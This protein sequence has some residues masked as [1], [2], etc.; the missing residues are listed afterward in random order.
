MFNRF[1]NAFRLT[2]GKLYMICNMVKRK[3]MIAVH[4]ALFSQ[5]SIKPGVFLN[6]NRMFHQKMRGMPPFCNTEHQSSAFFTINL[7]EAVANAK[8]RFSCPLKRLVKIC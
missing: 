4:K 7:L 5:C 8:N 6:M 1:R 3:I 2:C